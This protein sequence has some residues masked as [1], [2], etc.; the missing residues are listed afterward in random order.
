MRGAT[1]SSGGSHGVVGVP[2]P[3]FKFGSTLWS[4]IALAARLYP[5]I[6]GDP[7]ERWRRDHT[8]ECAG[9][10]KP[11]IVGHDQE[12]VRRALGR[13]HAG[14]PVP[15]SRIPLF[16]DYVVNHLSEAVDVSDQ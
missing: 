8:T 2:A 4:S 7:V 12:D 5:A 1:S 3:F 14:W 6:G 10:A 9:N 16:V 15:T 11:R 13:H